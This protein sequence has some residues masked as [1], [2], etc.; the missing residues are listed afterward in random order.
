MIVLHNEISTNLALRDSAKRLF[1]NINNSDDQEAILDFSNI[2]SISRSFTQEYMENKKKTSKSIK[3][4]NMP[5][6]VTKMF[7]VVNRNNPK[8]KLVETE[9]IQPIKL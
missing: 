3:E 4:I 5:L 1:D 7:E 9:K 2:I 6:N 8:I